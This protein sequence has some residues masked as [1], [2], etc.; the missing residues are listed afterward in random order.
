M[1]LYEK[2]SLLEKYEKAG[3]ILKKEKK[4]REREEQHDLIM[5]KINWNLIIN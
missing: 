3:S 2:V 1:A 5:F 4:E